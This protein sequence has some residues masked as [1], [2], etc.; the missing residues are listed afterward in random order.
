MP[1]LLIEAPPWVRGVFDHAWAP[2]QALGRQL[3]FLPVDLWDYL[4]GCSDPGGYLVIGAGE[5]RYVPGPALIRQQQLLNVGWVAV[6]DLAADN[7]EP[8][9]VVGHLIDHYLGC[10]GDAQG[11]WLSDPSGGG[12]RPRWQEAG[13]RLARLFAL[14]Y[15]A[16]PRARSDVRD[17]FA[18]SLALYCR[19]PQRLNV[20]DPQID[21][22]FRSTLWTKAFW[23]V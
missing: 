14:G 16:D 20:I 21:K 2:M 3:E 9:T 18:R 5:S 1:R 4:L 13:A 11:P 15:A 17:Y 19:D 12:A 22:W 10:A 8:L 6:E 23:Q 7:E